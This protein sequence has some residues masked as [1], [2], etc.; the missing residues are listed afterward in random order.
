MVTWI[1]RHI[2]TEALAVAKGY[3]VEDWKGNSRADQLAKRGSTSIIRAPRLRPAMTLLP[4]L[5]VPC[6]ST[7]F[8]PCSGALLPRSLRLT[9]R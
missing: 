1:K 8:L 6:M 2:P 5:F 4:F 3:T 7:S 9:K